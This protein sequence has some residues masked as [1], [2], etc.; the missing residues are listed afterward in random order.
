MFGAGFF[1]RVRHVILPLLKPAIQVALLFRII[2]AFEVFATSSSR[3]PAGRRRRLPTE[4]WRWQAD[5]FDSHVA[6][7]YAALILVLSLVAA[8]DRAS[9]LLR[10]PQ[11]ADAAMSGG[12]ARLARGC[13]RRSLYVVGDRALARGCSLPHLLH[14]ARR[15]LDA[16]RPSTPTRRELAAH[17]PVDG[18]AELLPQ[19]RRDHRRA[20]S[21]A[22]IV[23]ADHARRSRSRS[24]RRRATRSR[25]SR[26][27]GR[28]RSGSRS[29]RTR[30]FPIVILSIP[31]AV[32]FIR[33]GIDDSS[34]ASRSPTPRWRCRSRC[35]RRRASSPASR[36]SSRRP[37]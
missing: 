25:A 29:S 28:T 30:A 21:A 15:L 34:S 17:G 27:A 6:A 31:L 35:S 22:C 7:A 12:T 2:F 24:A 13:R 8:G 26:S 18:D 9:W 36:P 23:A 37:R 5:Y 14:H 32:I 10:T 33:W 20:R 11:G 1:Q 4:A 19:L 3:S 16:R